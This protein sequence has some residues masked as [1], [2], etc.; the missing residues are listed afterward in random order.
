[1]KVLAIGGSGGMRRFA[2]RAA[3]RFEQVDS[4]LVGDFNHEHALNFWLCWIKK[5]LA[6][7]PASKNSLSSLVPGSEMFRF[8]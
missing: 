8:A 3:E 1:M 5:F 2:V 4:I 7:E 6:Q